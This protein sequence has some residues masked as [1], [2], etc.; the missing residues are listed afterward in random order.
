[1]LNVIP[2]VPRRTVPAISLKGDAGSFQHLSYVSTLGPGESWQELG[3]VTLTSTQQFYPDL[4]LPLQSSRFY[5]AWQANVPSDKPAL[6]MRLATEL[7]LTGAISSHARIDRINQFGPTDAWV[8]LD[9]VT[10][11]N[12]TQPYFDFSMYLQPARLYRVEPVP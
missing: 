7:M 9:T 12:T 11:T 4:T 1:M 5:R 3:A 6:E 8:T 2:P 10:M